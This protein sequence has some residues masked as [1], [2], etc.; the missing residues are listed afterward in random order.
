MS[1]EQE[2]NE[3]QPCLHCQIVEPLVPN[4]F[5]YV[6]RR[7]KSCHS[8]QRVARRLVG[9]VRP[10]AVSRRLAPISRTGGICGYWSP[11]GPHFFSAL[12]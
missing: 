11:P 1:D 12:C 4:E 2:A 8:N 5:A 6:C 3:E 7:F 10:H 9:C